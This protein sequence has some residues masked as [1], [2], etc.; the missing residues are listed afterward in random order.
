M[1]IK[2]VGDQIRIASQVKKFRDKE[3]HRMSKRNTNRVRAEFILNPKTVEANKAG[4]NR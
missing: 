2:K 3:T 4:R 1:G